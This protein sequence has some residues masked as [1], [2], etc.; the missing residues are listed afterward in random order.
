MLRAQI[1]GAKGGGG[2]SRGKGGGRSG[3]S[4]GSGAS[5]HLNNNFLHV[6]LMYP[7]C[8]QVGGE[9]P[10]QVEQLPV[11][12]SNWE[13]RTRMLLPSLTVVARL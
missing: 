4:H 7:P 11:G 6:H 2:G 8:S 13:A 9:Q 3:G 10:L 1:A 5:S 12:V